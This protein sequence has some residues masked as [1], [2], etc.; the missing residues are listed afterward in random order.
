MKDL[1]KI[2]DEKIQELMGHYAA[3]KIDYQQFKALLDGHIL[4]A[5]RLELKGHAVELAARYA[6]KY[7]FVKD[8][9]ALRL[10]PSYGKEEDKEIAIEDEEEYC[11]IMKKD[12]TRAECLDYSGSEK[13]FEECRGCDTGLR[14]KRLVLGEPPLIDTAPVVKK[15]I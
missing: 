15:S 8:L 6:K 2:E 9:K 14:N 3:G 11:P 10:L 5:K 13:H 12:I 1:S 7:D 4:M